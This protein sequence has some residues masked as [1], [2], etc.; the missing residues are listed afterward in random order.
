MAARIDCVYPNG[1]SFKAN[2]TEAREIVKSNLGEWD[3]KRI[4]R[5][6]RQGQSGGRL[7]LRVGE[8]LASAVHRG[9]PWAH[10]QLADINR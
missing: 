5:M 6:K 9:E 10:V 2:V 8:T 3:G 4:I 7:S 1:S